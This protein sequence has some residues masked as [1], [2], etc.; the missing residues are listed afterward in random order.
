MSDRNSSP[1]AELSLSDGVVTLAPLKPTDAALVMTWDTDLEIQ[2]WFDWPLTP[3][4][5]EP[6]ARAARLARA[7][8]TI[9]DKHSRWSAGAEFVFAIRSVDAREGFGW[10]DLQPLGDG[11]GNISYGVLE[12]HRARGIATRSVK[13]ALGYAFDALD[14]TQLEIR[15][16]ADNVASRSVATKCGFVLQGIRENHGVMQHHEPLRGQSFDEAV[17]YL[18]R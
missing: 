16:N 1:S 5:S 3:G 4:T 12:R 2:R 8:Q 9:R 11:R 7:E 17:Y 13:L 6:A 18:R 10:L 15:A 14:W